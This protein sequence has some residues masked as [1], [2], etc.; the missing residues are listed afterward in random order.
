MTKGDLEDEG[1]RCAIGH[2]KLLGKAEGCAEVGSIEGCPSHYGL[3]S[4]QVPE[5]THQNWS[6]TH[7]DTSGRHWSKLSSCHGLVHL[8]LG[9]IAAGQTAAGQTAAGQKT[10]QQW[11]ANA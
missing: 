8:I 2:A 1:V 10:M 11:P 4:I 7:C 5:A 6:I 9:Q 3:I